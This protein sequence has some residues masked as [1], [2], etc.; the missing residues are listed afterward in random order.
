MTSFGGCDLI[1]K[2]HPAIELIGAVDELNA[3][4]GLFKA[5]YQ[6]EFFSVQ[7]RV[8]LERIQQKLFDVGGEIFMNRE[9][10]RY[11]TAEDVEELETVVAQLNEA[12]PPLKDFV[13][14]GVNVASAQA[15]VARTV[16]RRA[17][18][19]AVK[20]YSAHLDGKTPEYARYLNRLSD[21]LFVLARYAGGADGE[22]RL[23]KRP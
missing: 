16:C 17:E 9:D 3:H 8:L 21:V 20:Y 11:V 1:S 6:A 4:I 19:C 14:P 5:Q 23:W 18:V 12:L 22:G 10:R 15:H 2:G 7:F 13:F